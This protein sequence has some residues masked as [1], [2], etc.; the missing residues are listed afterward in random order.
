MTV[1][2]LTP[3]TK[4][5]SIYSDFRKDLAFS[6]ISGDIALLKDEDAVKDAIRN[7]LLTD[8]GERPMQPYLGGSIREMLFENLTPGTLQLIRDRVESTIKTYE[9]RAELI[10]VTVTSTF[11]D[12]AVGVRVQFYI[13]NVQQP[14]ELE[15]ILE[16]IR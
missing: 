1:R 8:R 13:V 16:R 2:V 4:K 5:V 14:I 3:V 11:D 10:D 7:L 6:P 15:I 9:P 12:N